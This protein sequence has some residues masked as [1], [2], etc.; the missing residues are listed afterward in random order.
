MPYEMKRGRIDKHMVSEALNR[1]RRAK[2][3]S[4][5]FDY[6][7]EEDHYFLLRQRGR[8][9]NWYVRAKGR[10]LKIGSARPGDADLL[11][12]K[13]ARALAGQRYY[14][15]RPK[16]ARGM[17][18]GW[19]WADLDRE[20]QASLMQ[21]RVVGNKIK[22]PVKGTQDEVRGCFNKPELEGWRRI[23]LAGLTP[24]HLR[25]LMDDII[26]RRGHSA[27]VKTSI[28]V[29]RALTWAQ[30]ERTLESGLAETMPW[31][32]NIR[33]PQPTGATI[34]KMEAR[35]R[36][37]VEAKEAFTVE[38]M[39]K[40]L[41]RHEEF[42]AERA[43]NEKISPGVRWGIWWLAVTANRRFTT[44]KLRH[45]DLQWTDPLNPYSASEAPWGIASWPAELVKGKIPFMLPIPPI[46][47]HI[48]RSCMWDWEV[49][50]RR[51]R[52][53]RS[54]T[55]WV[56][57]S[58]RRQARRGHPEN[59]D[60][61]IYPNSLNAHLRALRGRKKSGMNKADLLSDLPGFWPQLIRSV[62]TNFFDS[63]RR[64][65]PAAAASAM[66]AHVLP[67]DR[68]LDWRRMSKTTQDYYL[69]AQH[70]D[71][72]TEAMKLW[73]E[74]LLQAYL[75][76]GGTLPMPHEKHPDKP[77]GPGWILPRLPQL[78][79]SRRHH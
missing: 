50:V 17:G 48:A 1:A 34:L 29:K 62:T 77:K 8:T 43:G 2:D 18:A 56:F 61:S 73:S 12:V 14:A 58:T 5:V 72:K 66:I 51:K 27:C 13:A 52:G 19:T 32:K 38:H 55:Q 37:L 76:A 45:S 60:P 67:N 69:T 9:V 57:A 42:C 22:H 30:S 20:F 63:H 70:M 71:L 35:S 59:P 65:L 74:A 16:G 64:T 44:T 31:W 15:M 75:E 28:Y 11:T 78:P 41:A 54:G 46:G 39:G 53:F 24:L 10:S 4:A 68:D 21:P 79:R 26:A 33:P 25:K 49:L 23:R 6:F 36:A 40:L 47:L 3:S 7:D